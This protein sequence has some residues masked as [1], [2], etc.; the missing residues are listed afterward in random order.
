MSISVG[1]LLLISIEMLV[2]SCDEVKHRD[3]LTFFFDGVEPAKPQGFE[4]GPFDPNEGLGQSSQAPLWYVHEP[5]KD[6]T[7]CHGKRG[8]RRTS[9]QAFL[10]AP[11]P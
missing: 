9:R 11:V 7:L 10:V 6:C 2:V 3:A 5:R 4:I 8:R 1:L